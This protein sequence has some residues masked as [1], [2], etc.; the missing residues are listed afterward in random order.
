MGFLPKANPHAEGKAFLSFFGRLTEDQYK[1]FESSHDPIHG[2]VHGWWKGSPEAASEGNAGNP[3]VGKKHQ[4]G[5]CSG[6]EKRF[7]TLANETGK[8]VNIYYKMAETDAAYWVLRLE[9]TK[10]D[11][12]H[13]EKN[14]IAPAFKYCFKRRFHR[15][16]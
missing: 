7:Q 6:C 1:L 9:P 13:D 10:R 12:S 16:R 11:D 4:G 15:P 8:A 5:P 3:S 14:R 2:Y